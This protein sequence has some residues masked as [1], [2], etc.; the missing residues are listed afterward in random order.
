VKG[1]FI[2]ILGNEKR[3]LMKTHSER[4]VQARLEALFTFD[5][6]NITRIR[7]ELSG[8]GAI[9]EANNNVFEMQVPKQTD[10]V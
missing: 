7:H 4:L 3:L 10:V 2:Q 5:Y 1:E 9:L 8:K 6:Q